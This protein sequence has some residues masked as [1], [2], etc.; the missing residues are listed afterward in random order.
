M[1][2]LCKF[3]F[4]FISFTAVH[5]VRYFSQECAVFVKEFFMVFS[6]V[7]VPVAKINPA[8]EGIGFMDFAFTADEIIRNIAKA[9][10][11]D[12]IDGIK[13]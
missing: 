3:M 10:L 5:K 2:F 11:I 12:A 1:Q 8:T 6:A 9:T 7:L 4:I 13:K